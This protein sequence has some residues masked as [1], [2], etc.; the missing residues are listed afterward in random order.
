MRMVNGINL[1]KCTVALPLIFHICVWAVAHVTCVLVCFSTVKKLLQMRL[2]LTPFSYTAPNVSS[3]L[4]P[5]SSH[6]AAHTDYTG[7]LIE[8]STCREF[9]DRLETEW[10]FMNVR[11]TTWRGGWRSRHS[12]LSGYKLEPARRSE[13]HRD[14]RK[15]RRG[16]PQKENPV[17]NG[18]SRGWARG[19]VVVVVAVEL[20]R[21]RVRCWME[22][23]RE[24]VI[25]SLE[26]VCCP[27]GLL[28]R[29]SKGKGATRQ[30]PLIWIK[31]WRW[32]WRK[33][34]SLETW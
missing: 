16:E 7:V 3:C 28:W 30:V 29:V 9:I 1:F 17:A 18:P 15:R 11:C 23:E 31:G 12:C 2:R 13:V 21:R 27:Q 19:G 8:R 33:G 5:I 34:W 26:W 24:W 25:Y 6:H 10:G 4:W 20:G 22:G 32:R 14:S